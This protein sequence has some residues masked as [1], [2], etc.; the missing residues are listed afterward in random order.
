MKD[1]PF[2]ISNNSTLIHI[3]YELS[4]M[5]INELLN[6]LFN[7]LNQ[8]C[9]FAII[10][11]S[12]GT[13]KLVSYDPLNIKTNPLSNALKIV[14]CL[15]SLLEKQRD[16]GIKIATGLL[17]AVTLCYQD[18]HTD[19]VGDPANELEDLKTITSRIVVS[20]KFWDIYLA[21]VPEDRRIACRHVPVM[22][23]TVIQL[24]Q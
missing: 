15:L 10:G 14:E 7:S 13:I 4:G 11:T 17:K 19:L 2:V 1:V 23:G 18:V 12:Y 9:R 20:K 24:W 22:N 5:K 21:S 6:D 3:D 16:I 8:K